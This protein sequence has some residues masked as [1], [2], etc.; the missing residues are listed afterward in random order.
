[1]AVAVA[2]VTPWYVSSPAD[3]SPREL[4]RLTNFVNVLILGCFIIFSV[5]YANIVVTPVSYTHLDVYKRQL[6]FQ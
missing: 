5:A 6:Q 2:N 4:K 1:M 3:P